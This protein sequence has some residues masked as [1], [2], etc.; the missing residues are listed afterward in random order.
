MAIIAVEISIWSD[1]GT[2][3]E[4]IENTIEND[5]LVE[6]LAVDAAVAV[7]NSLATYL[8]VETRRIRYD[9]SVTG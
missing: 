9:A 8:K 7:R 6:E 1:D 4:D 3:H 2:I 5:E